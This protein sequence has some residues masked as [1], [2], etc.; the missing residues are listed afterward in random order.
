MRLA[1]LHECR[2]VGALHARAIADAHRKYL[3]DLAVVKP[4][5]MR[6][7]GLSWRIRQH[8]HNPQVVFD[9]K[10]VLDNRRAESASHS[11]RAMRG[12]LSCAEQA[13]S[14]LD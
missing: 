2:E 9:V 7:V 4:A 1:C 5:S 14:A 3:N 6:D 12:V 10:L 8:F 13:W 11:V